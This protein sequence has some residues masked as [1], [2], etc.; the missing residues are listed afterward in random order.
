M[1]EILF[2]CWIPSE[3]FMG[4]P[5]NPF[6]DFKE[7]DKPSKWRDDSI[8]L[9]FTGLKDK[10]GKQIYEGDIVSFLDEN[11]QVIY[12]EPYASFMLQHSNGN[13]LKN[14]YTEEIIIG[15]IYSNPELLKP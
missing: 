14:I 11:Y 8:F 4:V 12:M 5:F 2:K 15:N 13:D 9:Q 6:E 10:N 3:K 1:R 7:D